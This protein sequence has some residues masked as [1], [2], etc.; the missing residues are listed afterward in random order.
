MDLILSGLGGQG[1]LFITKILSLT[2]VDK[3][4]EVL[5]A[6]THGMAQR[7]GSVISH[8]RIGKKP[9]CS[10]I[11]T[12]SADFVIS[13]EE[14]EAYRNIPFLASSGKMYTNI[15]EKK[16]FNPNKRIRKYLEEQNIECNV[17]EATKIT[18]KFSAPLSLNLAVL[19]YFFS[20]KNSIFDKED[21]MEKIEEVSPERF[22]RKNLEIFNFCSSFVQ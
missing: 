17:I 8:L 22:R 21:V 20:F 10:L 16:D 4:Y 7:G 12:R 3:G 2:A 13:L 5:A 9:S 1:I 19:G 6:E 11:N 18:Q 15:S 14:N